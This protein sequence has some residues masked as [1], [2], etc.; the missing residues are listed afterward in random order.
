MN[1]SDLVILKVPNI[2]ETNKTK[3]K[4]YYFKKYED[5]EKFK[6]ENQSLSL[7]TQLEKNVKKY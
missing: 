6:L 2:F 1:I 7:N 5:I 3:N 4:K